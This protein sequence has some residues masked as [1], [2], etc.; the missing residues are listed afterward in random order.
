MR[1]RY[2]GD[3]FKMF[4]LDMKE[5]TIPYIYLWGTTLTAATLLPWLAIVMPFI[6][7]EGRGKGERR[8]GER[9]EEGRGKE[10]RGRGERREG[11]EE[12]RGKGEKR[13]ERKGR[14][15]E[16]MRQERRGDE[17]GGKGRGIASTTPHHLATYP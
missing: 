5:Y 12:R 10:G 13:M 8:E 2:N 1:K 15:E 6:A 4:K 11:G 16:K 7:Q 14:R 9:R 17:T 3:S